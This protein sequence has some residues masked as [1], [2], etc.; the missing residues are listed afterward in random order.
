LTH[1]RI[2][3]GKLLL[4]KVGEGNGGDEKVAFNLFQGEKERERVF[5]FCAAGQREEKMNERVF[6]KN[7]VVEYCNSPP[8]LW[9]VFVTPPLLPGPFP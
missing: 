5:I 3:G 8:L 6:E 2:C 9:H 7:N 1:P 4:P